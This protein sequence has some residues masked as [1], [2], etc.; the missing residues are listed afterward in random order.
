MVEIVEKPEA[1]EIRVV[2]ERIDEFVARVG[3]R[4]VECRIRPETLPPLNAFGRDAEAQR[5]AVG[6]G[7]CQELGR[8]RRPLEP[9]LVS[10]PKVV[11][12]V[13][14]AVNPVAMESIRLTEERIVGPGDQDCPVESG[15][16]NRGGSFE[17][18][19]LVDG[20]GVARRALLAIGVDR[21]YMVFEIWDAVV[22]ETIGRS[23]TSKIELIGPVQPAVDVVYLEVGIH[24]RGP[25]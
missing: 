12:A 20:D 9:P 16:H 22:M 8:H 14:R 6:Q 23:R 5:H 24:Y 25:G 7:R 4:S 15:A 10:A 2:L 18:Q 21:C 19:P 17:P 3:P 11:D 13:I 1:A